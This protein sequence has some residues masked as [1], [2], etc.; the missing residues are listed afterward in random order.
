[1]NAWRAK[2]DEPPASGNVVVPSAYEI[3]V[4]AKMKP[5]TANTSG[6]SPNACAATTPR[7]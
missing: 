3:A 2:D 7:A 6:V 1:L 5:A 4:I